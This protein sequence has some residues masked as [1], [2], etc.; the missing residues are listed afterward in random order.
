[1]NGW[2][3]IGVLAGLVVVGVGCNRNTPEPASVDLPSAQIRISIVR[4]ATDPF[5]QRFNLTM[6][7]KGAGGCSSTTDLFPD[8]GYTGRRN[9]YQTTQGLVYVVGQYDARVIDPRN[10]QARL[11]EFRHLER[12]VFFLG[13][14]DQDE[15]QQWVFIPASQRPER[16]FEKRS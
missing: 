16:P 1:M 4:L 10:C 5:L 12:V 7:V 6:T 3:W 14:F 2:G 15:M 11:S 9:V 13:S 8:T